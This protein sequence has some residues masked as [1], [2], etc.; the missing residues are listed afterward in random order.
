MLKTKRGK[1]NQKRIKEKEKSC[2]WAAPTPFRPSWLLS[3]RS[4]IPIPRPLTL[5]LARG[6][7]S[8]DLHPSPLSAPRRHVEPTCLLLNCTRVKTRP[9]TL[10]A[11]PQDR[12]SDARLCPPRATATSVHAVHHP[13]A[14]GFQLWSALTWG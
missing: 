1:R 5:P 2:S 14:S 12:L 6:L 4:P 3:P 11:G 10:I 13:K 7:A 8:P 9:Y